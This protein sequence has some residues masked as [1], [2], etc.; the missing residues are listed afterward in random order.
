[1][2][3]GWSDTYYTLSSS[4]M[5]RTVSN[6]AGYQLTRLAALGPAFWTTYHTL[7]E[8]SL[9]QSPFQAPGFL[10]YLSDKTSH[11]VYVYQF[12]KNDVLVGATVFQNRK[13]TLLFLS[14]V[15]SDHNYFILHE[16]TI[17]KDWDHFFEGLFQTIRDHRFCCEFNNLAGWASYHGSFEKSYQESPLFSKS[18]D[19]A[20]CPM[21]VKSSPAELGKKLKKSRT[22]RYKKN[23]LVREQ[24]ATFHAETD[25]ENISE[26][27][28]A[29]CAC[30]IER[31][32]DTPTPSAYRNP[33]KIYALEEFLRTWHADGLL[34]RFSIKT[35]DKI[36]AFCIGLLQQNSLIY[37]SPT[38]DEAFNKYSVGQ[39]LISFMGEWMQANNL[40]VLDF[41]HGSEKY[42]FRYA[43]EKGIL[44]TLF[45]APKSSFLF[46]GKASI[47]T[48]F[49]RRPYL[50]DKYRQHIRPV[51][52]QMQRWIQPN[53][54]VYG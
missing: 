46:C 4:I 39:V 45:L 22:N 44:K 26:W 49:R 17:A 12:F 14:Q 10:K 25:L 40:S 31:W 54:S 51:V 37:H 34:V 21:L 1:M 24:G 35:E 18:V 23:R 41:G 6:P 8:C 29:F 9:Y 19:S 28:S 30:H 33:N 27:T 2:L 7:W 53:K 16:K 47:I 50:I 5:N 36:I 52:I 20:V 38:Y 13:N 15:K 43:N 48:F 32:S 11:E 3:T 42:K